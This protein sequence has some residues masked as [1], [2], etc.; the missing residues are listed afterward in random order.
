MQLIAYWDTFQNSQW[1]QSNQCGLQYD[2]KKTHLFAEILG[3]LEVALD[4]EEPVV[5]EVGDDDVVAGREA[6]SPGRVEV[7]PHVALEAVLGD[8]VAVRLEQLDAVVPKR[9][10]FNMKNL[11]L[12]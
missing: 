2:F 5:V 3:G 7:L 10:K 1:C 6:D 11:A 9:V 12:D 8:E 4:D